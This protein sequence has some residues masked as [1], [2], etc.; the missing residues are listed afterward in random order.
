MRVPGNSNEDNDEGISV[1]AR[2]EI[3]YHGTTAPFNLICGRCFV[4][5]TGED[6]RKRRRSQTSRW[7]IP[8]KQKPMFTL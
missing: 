6:I 8:A 3:A 7:G 5:R 4:S 2:H 1:P